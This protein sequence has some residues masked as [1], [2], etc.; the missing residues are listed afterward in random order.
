MENRVV[1]Q[2][3]ARPLKLAALALLVASVATPCAF[4]TTPILFFEARP[5][6][7]IGNYVDGKLGIVQPTYARSHLVVA[8]RYFS[9]NPP[10]AA[11]R[12]GFLAVLQH[13]LKEGPG[14]VDPAETWERLRTKIR[15]E[16]YKWPP[17]R[18][19]SA[20][21]AYEFFTNCGDDAFATAATTLE[22]RMKTFGATNPAVMRW[23]DAQE[24]VFANCT[25]GKEIPQDDPSL[26]PLLRQDRQYQT[27]AANFY[28]LRYDDARRQFLAIARDKNSPWAKTARL[29][30]TRVLIR[31]ENL[32]VPIEE[33]DPLTLADEE[34]RAILADASM[35]SLHDA[36]WDLLQVTTFRRD[37]GQRMRDA[38]KGIT[39]GE[40]EARRVRTHFADYTLLLDK[41]VKSDDDMTDWITTFQSGN[42]AR[43]FEKWQATKKTHWLVA[44]ITHVKPEDASVATL[45]EATVPADSPAATQI[46][47]HRARLLLAAERDDD[48]RAELDRALARDIP[49]S[50]RNQLLEERRGLAKS[51][52]DFLRDVPATPVGEGPDTI[53]PGAQPTLPEDAAAVL[54]Y[55]TPLKTLQLMAKDESLPEGI[56]S[57]IAGAASTREMLLKKPTFD[58]A[59]ALAQDRSFTPYMHPLDGGAGGW[60]CANGLPYDAALVSATRL[61]PF[62]YDTAKTA[63]AEI[64]KLRALGSGASW[65]LRTAMARAKSH[66]DDERVPELLSLAI[67]GTRYACG[68]AD[69]E[70]LAKQAFGVLHRQYAK[71]TWAH[72]TPYW[73]KP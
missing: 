23:L 5:D 27:A 57:R 63:D 32:N 38:V 11:E 44:A 49:T 12:E 65:I 62:L 54:N 18:T 4:D 41:D 59:Y 33:N 73:Y 30:A 50:A 72:D 34:L 17:D 6:A 52:A 29:V 61:P 71:T 70:K 43:A 1:A 16:P 2:R 66:P 55:W 56:R 15:G 9:G 19:H 37:P 42:F 53:E 10:A 31:A 69:T 58:T 47:Y 13:R 40:R 28:A 21:D 22:S 60:W 8:Y 35:K 3:G 46:A 67:K 36:A 14:E 24:L 7:P 48:A 51:L 26:P 25:E 64:E 39:G 45:L 20:T 68:D